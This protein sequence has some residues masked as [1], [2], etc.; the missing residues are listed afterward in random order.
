MKKLFTN[1]IFLTLLSFGLTAIALSTIGDIGWIFMAFPVYMVIMGIVYGFILNPLRDR[2]NTKR[3]LSYKGVLKG[4]VTYRKKPLGMVS[5]CIAK[6]SIDN[7]DEGYDERYDFSNYHTLTDNDG[8]FTIP[9]VRNGNLKCVAYLKEYQKYETFFTITDENSVVDL[10][11]KLL[12][13]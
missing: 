9:Y 1:K 6:D 5:V 4:N 12:K 10:E 11:I 13:S 8:N 3:Y 2:R 7:L